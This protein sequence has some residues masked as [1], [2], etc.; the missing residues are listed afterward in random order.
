ME[1]DTVS[2]TWLEVANMKSAR[3]GPGVSVI[4]FNHV[5]D[6]VTDCISGKLLNLKHIKSNNIS[7]FKRDY[8]RCQQTD[9]LSAG[10]VH[11]LVQ[12]GWV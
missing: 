11:R 9:F 6:S 7:T 5:K 2:E 1:F 8:W 3:G 10:F 4:D 12:R